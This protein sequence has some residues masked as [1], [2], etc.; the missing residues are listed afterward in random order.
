[1][2]LVYRDTIVDV[3][4]I[5]TERHYTIFAD[6]TFER[7]EVHAYFDNMT[8]KLVQ[9]YPKKKDDAMIITV[10]VRNLE[11]PTKLDI[12]DI[13]YKFP[14]NM[15][16]C[17][18]FWKS[19]I[20]AHNDKLL[21]VSYIDNEEDLT[22]WIVNFRG[23]KIITHI[24]DNKICIQDFD[25]NYIYMISGEDSTSIISRS[26]YN[27]DELIYEIMFKTDNE[28]WCDEFFLQDNKYL[29]LVENEEISG[30]TII[31][32]DAN[33]SF[34][35]IGINLPYDMRRQEFI[36]FINL[37]YVLIS[38]R[39]DNSLLLYRISDG[40]VTQLIIND[41]DDVL[42]TSVSYYIENGKLTIWF[43]E[44]GSECNNMYKFSGYL[45][46]E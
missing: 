34:P 19:S 1:M 37:N 13:N 45:P 24:I 15:A 5:V 23:G 41:F 36:G 25:E 27:C 39:I 20:I 40:N 26:K 28:L 30:L 43:Y 33:L 10:K 21:F 18:T 35:I 6:D 31:G 42:N 44:D 46:I 38:N 22:L 12:I 11:N 17:D 32:K 14:L 7:G 4:P 16:I 3:G 9:I 29:F 8:H 2:E